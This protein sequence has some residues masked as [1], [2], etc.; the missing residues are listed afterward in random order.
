M[1]TFLV[2]TV[3]AVMLAGVAHAGFGIHADAAMQNKTY[4]QQDSIGNYYRQVDVTKF[5]EYETLAAKVDL[6][7][8]NPQVVEDNYNK[9]V[10]L[11][12]NHYGQ[13]RFKSLYFKEEDRIKIIDYRGGLVYE[14]I[15][16]KTAV[17][18]SKG[19]DN[20]RSISSDHTALPEYQ[21][22][23][24]QTDL[25]GYMVR[26]V[27]DNPNKRTVLYIDANGRSQYKTIYIKETEYV[28]VI[29]L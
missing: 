22:L 20:V 11:L 29:K 4:Y 23:S 10:I 28:K 27:E 18:D 13:P 9:R 7:K 1:K 26:I 3:G 2:T 25:T 14:G 12:K 24:T 21:V 19:V 15:I 16:G 6:T 8:Y 5:P 17:H